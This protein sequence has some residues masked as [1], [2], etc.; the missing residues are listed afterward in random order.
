[1]HVLE[2]YQQVIRRSQR[3]S[4]IT[5]TKLRVTMMC[6]PSEELDVKG[7]A[8]LGLPSK[9]PKWIRSVQV[10]LHSTLGPCPD[11]LAASAIEFSKSIGACGSGTSDTAGMP[12]RQMVHFSILAF[13]CTEEQAVASAEAV[14]N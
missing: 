10:G 14:S 12:D 6:L 11:L 2:L 7:T 4:G 9:L 8:N 5:L 13:I 1:M 3:G